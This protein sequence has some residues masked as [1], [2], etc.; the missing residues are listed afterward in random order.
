[1]AVNPAGLVIIGNDGGPIQ[2]SGYAFTDVLPGQ[3]AYCGSKAAPVSSGNNSF[4]TSDILIG[5]SA[6]GTNFPVGL[7]TGS[8]TSGNGVTVMKKGTVIMRADG[9]VDAGAYVVNLNG[10]DCVSTISGTAMS[11]LNVNQMLGKALTSAGS[12]EYCIVRLDL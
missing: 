7:I 5:V 8:I 9:A 2:F 6:S 3:V 12:T 11:S 4:V 10:A 1:M